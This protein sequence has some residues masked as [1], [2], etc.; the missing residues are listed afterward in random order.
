VLGEPTEPRHRTALEL[1]SGPEVKDV[2]LKRYHSHRRGAILAYLVKDDDNAD[3]P[4]IF[5][6]RLYLPRSV[7][8]PVGPVIRFRAVQ[9]QSR[10]ATVTTDA[11]S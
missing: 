6:F 1:L 8:P 7:I 11:E 3:S 4:L 9:P 10:A 2:T 5:A